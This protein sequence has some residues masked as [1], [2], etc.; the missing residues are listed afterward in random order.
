MAQVP[1][2]TYYEIAKPC[3]IWFGHQVESLVYKIDVDLAAQSDRCNRGLNPNAIYVI[4]AVLA[5]CLLCFWCAVW[6]GIRSVLSILCF[7]L[8]V[9]RAVLC[10]C[11][12]VC[13]EKKN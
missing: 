13:D 2:P 11:C 7:P 12:G 9:V 5:L 10:R 1:P 4:Y 6:S 8:V 3:C